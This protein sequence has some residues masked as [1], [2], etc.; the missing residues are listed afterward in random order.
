MAFC[1][2]CINE[3]FLRHQRRPPLQKITASFSV[4][5]S[6]PRGT[7]T[8]YG[9]M[10]HRNSSSSVVGLCDESHLVTTWT[11]H[12]MRFR[13]SQSEHQGAGGR[14]GD[15]H[16]CSQLSKPWLSS[17]NHLLILGGGGGV[18]QDVKS[19]GPQ[20][21]SHGLVPVCSLLGAQL[22]SRRWATRASCLFTA[23]LSAPGLPRR[24]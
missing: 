6:S 21:Q 5:S 11:A 13:G 22:H 16:Y 8:I 15:C 7:H 17:H 3:V 23:T 1:L 18:R 12:H 9:I 2:P 24:H 10:K 19:R 14:M 4:N 20:H